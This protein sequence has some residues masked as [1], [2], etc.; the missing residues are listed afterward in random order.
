MVESCSIDDILTH[1]AV[2]LCA[3]Q[4]AASA[5]PRL[6]QLSGT[7]REALDLTDVLERLTVFDTVENAIRSYKR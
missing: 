4:H 2:E 1:L 5:G 6:A 7:S 3:G